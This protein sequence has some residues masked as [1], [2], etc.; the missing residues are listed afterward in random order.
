MLI[1]TRWI[2]NEPEILNLEI[3]NAITDIKVNDSLDVDLVGFKG[4]NLKSFAHTKTFSENFLF[5]IFSNK[6]KY[7]D[8]LLSS[9]NC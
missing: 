8:R 4:A 7:I 2:A 1:N 6:T 9:L 3:L 5:K